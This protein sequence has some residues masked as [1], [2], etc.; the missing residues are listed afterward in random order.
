M[1]STPRF[2]PSSYRRRAR[3]GAVIVLFAI[4]L[5]VVMAFLALSIDLGYACAVKADLQSAVDAGALA[6]GGALVS[7]TD[8]AVDAAEQFTNLN[9]NN[10]GVQVSSGSHNVQVDL[11]NWNSKNRLFR[12]G[13]TPQ[14]AVRVTVQVNNAGLFFGKAFGGKR[15]S[16][17]ATA[18]ATYR[19]RDIMLVLDVSGSMNESRNSIKKIEELRRAVTLFFNFLQVA[20]VDERV[21]FT[22]FS[23]EAHLGHRLDSDLSEVEE[24][25]MDKLD[26]GGYTNIADGMKLALDE[27]EEHRRSYAQPLMVVLT[28]GA[29]NM[30]QPGD[31]FDPTEA[32]AR[33][34]QRANNALDEEIP[35]FTIALDSL[36]AEV[37]VALMQQVS[38]ITGSESVHVL[39][40]EPGEVGGT[41]LEEVF[42]RVAEAHPLRLVD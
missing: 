34:L 15:L 37:D 39:A 31:W 36:T 23:T 17:E 10:S 1:V 21:G 42:R 40:G 8:A 38:V 28:D 30:N 19:P 11:G 6:G 14:N 3:R 25:V 29:A 9:L 5:I 35:V 33:V 2:E 27:F 12:D 7:G 22:Y 20:K 13:V 32:K 41:Q 4:L 16:S 24:E 26:P 18:I